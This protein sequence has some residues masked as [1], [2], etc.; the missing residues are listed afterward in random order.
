MRAEKA[1][2]KLVYYKKHDI[3]CHF[4]AWEQPQLF[5]EDVRA[6]FRTLRPK[7]T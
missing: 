1:Y 6:T 3:G 4:A 7:S 2:P 5:C